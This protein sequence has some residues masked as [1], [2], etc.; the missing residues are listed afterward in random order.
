[1][2]QQWIDWLDNEIVRCS[3]NHVLG[4]MK[5]IALTLNSDA[6]M[7]FCNDHFLELTG[8]S[9]SE[10][11]GCDYFQLFVPQDQVDLRKMFA[12]ALQGLP[13]SWHHENEILCRSGEKLLVRWNNSAIK[14]PSGNIIGV[15]S[16]G[17]DIT[18]QRTL[19]SH[20][21]E[22]GITEA[23]RALVSAASEP[24]PALALKITGAARQLDLTTADHLYR[25]AQE[26]IANSVAHAGASQVRV[27]LDVQPQQ[28]TL[29]IV[30]DGVG[31]PDGWTRKK[32]LGIRLMKHRASTIGATLTVRRRSVLGT[33]VRCECPRSHG[34]AV[35]H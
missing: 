33:E 31:I 9:R 32:C 21:V 22:G 1:M 18:H 10:V 7:S 19:K 15:A 23:L 3:F 4:N 34:P 14:S 13:S 29:S 27:R 5:V 25:I 35:I 12:H 16:I 20:L 8:Y 6:R 30:D 2:D 24:S 17:E 11:Q 28:V 26:A